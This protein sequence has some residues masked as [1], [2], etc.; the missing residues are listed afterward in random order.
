MKSAGQLAVLLALLQAP[1]CLAQNLVCQKEVWLPVNS[2]LHMDDNCELYDGSLIPNCQYFLNNVTSYYHVHEYDCSKFWECGPSGPCLFQCGECEFCG[3]NN[4]LSFDC[5][6]QYP[7]GPTCDWPNNVNCTND[8]PCTDECCSEADCPGGQCVDGSCVFDWTTTTLAPS[9]PSPTPATTTTEPQTTRT[10]TT[11]A[12]TTETDCPNECCSDSECQVGYCSEAGQC[13]GDCNSDSDCLATAVCSHCEA[14]FC[15]QPECCLNEDCL[16]G[17]CE[18]GQCVEGECSVDKPCEGADIICDL[19]GEV[20][21]CEYCDLETLEC[22][23]GCETDDNCP[24]NKPTCSGHTCIHVDVNG[25]VNITVST[26]SCSLCEGSGNPLG[27]VEGGLKVHLIGDWGTQCD[28]AGLDNRE[29]VDY[30]N[31]MTSFFDGTPD[32]DADDDGLGGCK[33]ADLNYG[34]N[35]GTAEWTGPGTWTG[36]ETKTVCIK[37]YDPEDHL[38]TCC[39]SLEDRSLGQGEISALKD[40]LCEI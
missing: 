22:N 2:T 32:D 21:G 1:H 9:T 12:S 19:E 6:Y 7:Y 39:C 5:R 30:D 15:S 28:S 26:E 20:L 14:H 33:L 38:P 31:G 4:R 17:T 27:Y 34:L 10:T 25:I 3:P 11:A 36:A 23:P 35:G 37:F 29:K 18:D 40:C 8:N 24:F 16:D 13:E